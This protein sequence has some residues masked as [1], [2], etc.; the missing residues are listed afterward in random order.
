MSAR[1]WRLAFYGLLI[2]L[3]VIIL[4]HYFPHLFPALDERLSGH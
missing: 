2:I 4:A 3:A 1:D